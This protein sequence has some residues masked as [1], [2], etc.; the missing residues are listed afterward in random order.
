MSATDLFNLFSWFDAAALGWL[1]VAWAGIGWWI[2][3]PHYGKNSVTSLMKGY[4]RAWMREM[5]LRDPRIFD[6]QMMGSLRQSTAFFAS[7]SIIAIGGVL[8]LSGNT[9]PLQGVATDLS[10]EQT[11]R[12]SGS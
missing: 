4:R 8:A 1:F 10:G 7:S 11:P 2:D 9:A 12:L 5:V 3:H 6:A